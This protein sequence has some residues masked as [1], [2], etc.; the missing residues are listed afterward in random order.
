MKFK[1]ILV[2]LD[3]RTTNVLSLQFFEKKKKKSR[4]ISQGDSVGSPR[5]KLQTPALHADLT[6]KSANECCRQT[7][8]IHPH[9]Y[10]ML[11]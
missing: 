8:Q 5:S 7:P 1:L 6:Q 11:P 3:S 9:T 10:G 2:D 4:G